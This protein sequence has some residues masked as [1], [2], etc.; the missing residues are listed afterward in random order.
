MFKDKIV[1][2]NAEDHPAFFT[3]IPQLWNIASVLYSYGILQRKGLGK[4]Q[5]FIYLM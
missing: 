4:K 5:S 3:Q 2:K 1:K